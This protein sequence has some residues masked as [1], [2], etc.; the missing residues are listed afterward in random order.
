METETKQAMNDADRVSEAGEMDESKTN[1]MNEMNEDSTNEDET[2]EMSQENEDRPKLFDF[3]IIV[4]EHKKITSDIITLYEYAS[5]IATRSAQL[6]R[7]CTSFVPVDEHEPPVEIAKKEL[8]SR[9]CPLLIR[10]RIG[11]NMVEICNPNEM[12]IPTR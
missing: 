4:D 7:G 12:E 5:L 8:R 11:K 3:D 10:R 1:E 6:E 9:R 2:N